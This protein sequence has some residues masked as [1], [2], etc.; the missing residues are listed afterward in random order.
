MIGDAVSA[1]N[2]AVYTAA[3]FAEYDYSTEAVEVSLKL[4]YAD[5][6][7]RYLLSTSHLVESGHSDRL[8]EYVVEQL[9]SGPSDDV[10]RSVIPEGTRLLD[11]SVDDGVCTLNFNQAFYDNRPVSEAHERMLVYSIVNSVTSLSGID[12]V[13]FEIEN[14]PAGMY[15][16]MD[17]SLVYPFCED[18]VGPVRT[19]VNE[20]DSTVYMLGANDELLAALPLR[21]RKSASE[22]NAE[23]LMRKLLSYTPPTGMRN[24][25][26]SGTRLL[27]I[28]IEGLV[29]RVDLSKEFL[30]REDDLAVR[31]V[32]ASL[33]SL[34]G[35]Y[36]IQLLVEG[37]PCTSILQPNAAWGY[38][39][40]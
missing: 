17:L 5:Q 10:M 6:T 9:I 34:S 7:Y 1:Q 27:G 22:I 2:K 4:Y 19:A 23:A 28:A 3:D 33:S 30:A 14:T 21:V 11:S 15:Q 39:N 20:F 37:E 40:P 31:C 18:V 32:I 38:P 36:R 8:P 16:Y 24:P 35:I 12:A 26:P 29:C 13:C 25:I